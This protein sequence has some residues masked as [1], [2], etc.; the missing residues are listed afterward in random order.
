MPVIVLDE[1]Q[2]FDYDQE[3]VNPP[4]ANFAVDIVEGFAPLTV[5]FTSLTEDASNWEWDFQNNDSWDAVGKEKNFH[6]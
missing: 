4:I 6:F 3:I 1:I 2:D 5:K